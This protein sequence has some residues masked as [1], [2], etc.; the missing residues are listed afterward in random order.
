MA[1]RRQDRAAAAFAEMPSHAVPLRSSTWCA[2]KGCEK[3]LLSY[4]CARA[5][6]PFS[7]SSAPTVWVAIQ[8]TGN[9]QRGH[10]GAFGS[11]V[12][13]A[14]P[15][16]ACDH[17][18]S[19]ASLSP[20]ELAASGEGAALLAS[21]MRCRGVPGREG[22]PEGQAEGAAATRPRTARP[23]TPRARRFSRRAGNS[24]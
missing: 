7:S 22:K 9:L 15:R 2:P 11:L 3:Y 21:A 12:A 16:I 24:L 20:M 4:F 23:L 13:R 18:V 1:R 5:R 19:L 17:G 6:G 10:C 14:S 8:I